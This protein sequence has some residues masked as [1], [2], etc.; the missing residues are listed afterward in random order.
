MFPYLSGFV[1]WRANTERKKK[2]LCI[3]MTLKTWTSLKDFSLIFFCEMKKK[4]TLDP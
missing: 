3:E 2:S 4:V 1:I